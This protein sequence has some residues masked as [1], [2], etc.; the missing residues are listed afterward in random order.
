M[1]LEIRTDLSF[2]GYKQVTQDINNG[3]PIKKVQAH[4]GGVASIIFHSDSVSTHLIC[5]SG[6][7]DGMLNIFDM[8]TN[9]P[10]FSQQIHK[11]AINQLADD[12]SGNSRPVYDK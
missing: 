12:M 8:R 10:L 1:Y 2:F 3:K 4:S 9:K 7:N 11:G 5:T 6:I